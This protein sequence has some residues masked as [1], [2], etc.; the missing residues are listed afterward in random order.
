MNHQFSFELQHVDRRSGARAGLLRVRGQ[1]IPTPIFMP[2]GTLGSVKG[3]TADLI[4]STKAKIVLCNT[5]HLALRP[6]EEV[7]ESLGGLHR[8]MDW[9][10]P[11]L[12]DSGGFQVFSLSK[13]N[14]VTE[15]GVTFQSH[16]DGSKIEI[17]PERSIEIQQRLGSDIAMVFDHVI[18]LPN[19]RS[20]I[21]EA[22]DR[23]SRWAAR[24]KEFADHPYQVLFGIVQGGLI[25]ELR[26]KSAKA[27]TDL[28]FPGYAIGGLSV[29]ESPAEMYSTIDVT[30]P[31]LPQEKPRYLMGV[32]RPEDLIEGVKRGIDMF[33]CVMPTRNGRNALAFT[34]SGTLRF[35]N[36]VHQR[37]RSPIQDGFESAVSKYSR[38]YI[39]H[40]FQANEMLGPIILSVHNLTYYQKLMINAREAI[41]ADRFAEFC[42]EKFASWN[43][44]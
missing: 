35:R 3:L 4:R 17:T 34:D 20:N 37:D 18:E 44:S 22:C 26:E 10:G 24:C 39:R 27:L 41:F 30:C 21:E 31:H 2:V 14:K 12:T 15:S 28:D 8:F 32:G 7:V 42:E 1:E 36:Q 38:G 23:S 29:G 25:P 5:Y 43:D 11:I 33:D 40:L 13:M 16:I 9:Q 6:G 19:S